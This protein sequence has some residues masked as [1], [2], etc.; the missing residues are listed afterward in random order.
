MALRDCQ[1]EALLP[2]H[3]AGQP[4]VV[5]AQPS[6]TDVDTAVLEGH[7]LL[8][9]CHFRQR[10]FDI[11][12]SEAKASD[13]LRQRIVERRGHEADAELLP[14][15]LADALR[16]GAHLVDPLQDHARLLEEIAPRL[17]QCD[18]PATVQELGADLLFQ[19]LDLPAE[20]RLGDVQELGGAAE[21]ALGGHAHE[22]AQ[23]TKLHQH[24]SRV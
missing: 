17:G 5:E 1:H 11:R 2:Y 14:R 13:E 9:R 6:E 10:D 12:H 23:M 15:A 7:R 20:R 19:L 8:E 21:A 3:T 18:R 4:L 16:H 24:T 22:I